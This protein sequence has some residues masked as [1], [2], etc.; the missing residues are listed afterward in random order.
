[1]LSLSGK[2][3]LIVQGPGFSTAELRA[4]LERRGANA[5]IVADVPS[6][7]LLVDRLPFDGAIIDRAL[8]NNVFDFCTELQALYI[9]YISVAGPHCSQKPTSRM[10]DAEKAANN[11]IAV[12]SQDVDD[13]PEDWLVVDF[14]SGPK[15]EAPMEIEDK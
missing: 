9:P 12:F 6:A 2:S 14:S 3:I 15:A 10:R 8:Q 11:L 5:V 7:F 13:A 4:E 1:M